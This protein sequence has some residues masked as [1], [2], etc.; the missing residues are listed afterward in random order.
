MTE[1]IPETV[2]FLRVA[3]AVIL[4]DGHVLIASRKQGD[5][6]A[7]KWEFPG[8]K[9]EPGE[10][11]QETLHRELLEELDVETE[12]GV[13]LGVFPVLRTDAP[14]IELIAFQTKIISGEVQCREHQEI[15][16]VRVEDLDLFDFT[17]P[18]RLLIENLFPSLK[19]SSTGPGGKP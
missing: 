2:S 6:F 16:R 18:D 15:R 8:G 10:T 3:A 1:K 11:P 14:P 4:E 9:I 13:P 7:G 19:S 17:E 12:I 5:R